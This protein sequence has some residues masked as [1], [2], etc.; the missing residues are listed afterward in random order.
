[1]ENETDTEQQHAHQIASKAVQSST[2]SIGA[3]FITIASGFVR[4]I[5]LA[6][7][8]A[9]KDFGLVALAL[10]FAN[11]ATMITTF[12]FNAT[13]IQYKGNVAKA[14]STHFILRV[15]FA[16]AV[17]LIALVVAP[18]LHYFYP[19]R[20]LLVP[21][22]LAVLAIRIVAAANATP[23]TL[24]Q[25]R[26]EFKRL[27]VLNVISSLVMTIVAPLLAWS[28]WG[29][30]SLVIGE[31]GASVAV[32]AVGLWL[33]RRVYR[34][35][36]QLDRQ[37]ARHYF[38]F[39]F[40]VMVSRQLTF[41]LDQFDEFWTG[42]FLGDTA[43]GY[44]SKAYEFARYPRRIVARPLQD[45][46]FSTY[47]RLQ[48]DRTRLS[49]AYYRVNSLVVRLGFLFSLIL[50]LSAREFVAIL[51][52]AEWLPMVSAFQLMVVYCLFDP[53]ILTSGQLTVAVGQPQIL[54][55]IKVIQLIIFVPAVIVLGSY[56]GI[57]G[58]AVA[59]DIMLFVGIGL[60]LRQIRQFVD[61]SL[62]R[63]FGFPLLALLL[64]AGASLAAAA[65]LDL[66]QDWL[67]LI[68]KTGVAGAVYV[69]TLWIWERNE[70]R[71]TLAYLVRLVKDR[72][73]TQA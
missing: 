3:S 60:I 34:A 71:R 31:Q 64:A 67:L 26:L 30:W 39:G 68:V 13:L 22:L 43:L 62:A 46:V 28:G 8:L 10:F 47:A 29:I 6:R 57:E 27:M 65:L 58:V 54:T 42:T 12:G 61:F 55:K 36:L 20:S 24:L 70:Y 51:L 18:L 16:I 52:R 37:V 69:G 38:R 9:P 66:Q 2:W 49:K 59:A 40:F 7:L 14:A 45:V 63:M 48:D 56:F 32:S 19:D 5:L 73:T 4:S 15:S 21:A 35:R 50:I 72:R 53:L 33:V 11:M 23:E 44:Y 17:V 1:L 25:R 41:W